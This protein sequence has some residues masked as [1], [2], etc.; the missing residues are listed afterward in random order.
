MSKDEAEL[1]L[2]SGLQLDPVC[3]KIR[4]RDLCFDSPPTPIALNTAVLE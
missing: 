4:R 3:R 2:R 1:A